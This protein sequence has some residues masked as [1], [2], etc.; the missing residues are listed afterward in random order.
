MW[1]GLQ[2][3][4]SFRASIWSF[5]RS[6]SLR[7]LPHLKALGLELGAFQPRSSVLKASGFKVSGLSLLGRRIAAESFDVSGEPKTRFEPE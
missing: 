2:G 7:L 5:H 3:L 6:F 1:I 4:E